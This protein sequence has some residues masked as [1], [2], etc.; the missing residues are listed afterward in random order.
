MRN[1]WLSNRIFQDYDDVVAHGCHYWER[2]IKQSWRI[3][4]IS[5]RE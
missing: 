3:L 5:L 1:N 4:S 2:L